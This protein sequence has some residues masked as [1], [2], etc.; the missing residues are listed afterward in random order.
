MDNKLLITILLDN[1]LSLPEEELNGFLLRFQGFLDQ[2]RK[3]KKPEAVEV[4]LLCYNDFAP[5]VAKP[6]TGDLDSKLVGPGRMPF[7]DRM[8]GKA[9]ETTN[10]RTTELS[11]KGVPFYKPW[12][13]TVIDSKTFDTSFKSLELLRGL[14]QSG[15]LSYF[16]FK[17]KKTLAPTMKELEKI[18]P[19]IEIVDH[20][21]EGLFAWLYDMA[22]E[23][24]DKLPGEPVKLKKEALAGWTAL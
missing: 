16:P 8:L 24:I 23:R 9:L 14:V 21:F 6:F 4:Q 10:E 3:S 20:R 2:L 12:L 15:K 1:S 22:M 17:M 11:S 19:F 5:I 13:V 18:R 7:F